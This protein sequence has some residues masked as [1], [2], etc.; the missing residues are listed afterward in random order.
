MPAARGASVLFDRRPFYLI[1]SATGLVLAAILY[2]AVP[3]ITPERRVQEQLAL[4]AHEPWTH[5]RIDGVQVGGGAPDQ[6]IV[7]G[8]R[9]DTNAPVRIEFIA[10]S[11]YTSPT[12]MKRL[13]E[14]A[15]EGQVADILML[16]RSITFE[17]YRSQFV[18]AATHAGVAVF[19]GFPQAPTSTVTPASASMNVETP[20]ASETPGAPPAA[21]AT[22]APAHG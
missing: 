22:S 18:P 5:V 7:T 17:P 14:R 6:A 16:P 21:P 12:A 20:A 1:G 15:L 10:K 9:L 4:L 2:F 8:V 19:A 11:P 3:K 13:T